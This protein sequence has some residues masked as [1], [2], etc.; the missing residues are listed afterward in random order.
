MILIPHLFFSAVIA[1]KIPFLPLAVI[2]IVIGHY[3]LDMIPHTEYSISNI[4]KGNWKKTTP[5]FGRV[6]ADLAI[7]TFLV[8]FI[9]EFTPTPHYILFIGAFIGI[10]PDILTVLGII[11]PKNKLLKTHYKFHKRLHFLEE[12]KISHFER[13]AT[14]V[15]TVMISF[16]ILTS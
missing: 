1:A 15:L 3:L 14:Q 11:F 7:G 2:L 5:D 12:K 4:K 16:A 6:A 10:L 8:L 13:V 9:G